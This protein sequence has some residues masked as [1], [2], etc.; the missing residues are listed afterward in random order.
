MWINAARSLD[1]QFSALTKSQIADDAQDKGIATEDVD[2]KRSLDGDGFIEGEV[3]D[4][5]E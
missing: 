5:N 3:K 1:G 4:K 2:V